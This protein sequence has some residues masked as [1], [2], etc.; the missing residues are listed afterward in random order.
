VRQRHLSHLWIFLLTIPALAA[1]YLSD[2]LVAGRSSAAASTLESTF[3]LPGGY[4]VRDI[5]LEINRPKS[6]AQVIFTLDGSVP[7]HASGTIYT[8]PIYLSGDTPS[9]TVVRARAVLPAASWG[10]LPAP[11]ISSV[12]RRRCQ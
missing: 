8:Q 9:V 11:P 4:Y 10:Q 3:S 5:H 2:T 1:L 7:T 12:C 6:A